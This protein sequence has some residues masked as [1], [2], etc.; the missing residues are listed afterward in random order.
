MKT[1]IT[2]APLVLACLFLSA[3]SHSHNRTEQPTEESYLSLGEFPASRDVAKNIPVD[4]YDEILLSPPTKV[5][6]ETP[7][8]EQTISK[9][10]P[11]PFRVGLKAVATPVF[12]ADGTS[13]VVLKGTFSCIPEQYSLSSAPQMLTTS[14]FV[15]E[16]EASPGDL[17]VVHASLPA[18]G[19]CT[20]D[21]KDLPVMLLIK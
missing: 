5:S 1:E 20:K 16:K 13:K 18:E 17:L 15:L 21:K 19:R 12:N 14:E 3:C 6:T 9:A 7:E 2:F 10:R 8:D 4:I 11:E